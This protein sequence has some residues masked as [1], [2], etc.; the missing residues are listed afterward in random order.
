MQVTGA[1]PAP[2][3]EVVEELEELLASQTNEIAALEVHATARDTVERGAR[4]GMDHAL[5]RARADYEG[6]RMDGYLERLKEAMQG[7]QKLITQ[8]VN[9]QIVQM[10][11]AGYSEEAQDAFI[12]YLRRALAL[13]EGERCSDEA[14]GEVADVFHRLRPAL[15]GSRQSLRSL[16]RFAHEHGFRIRRSERGPSDEMSRQLD[17]SHYRDTLRSMLAA[18]EPL[19]RRAVRELLVPLVSVMDR[20]DLQWARWQVVGRV[21]FGDLR[22]DGRESRDRFERFFIERLPDAP[23]LHPRVLGH[24][25]RALRETIDAGHGAPEIAG[26][27]QRLLDDARQ[28]GRHP[29]ALFFGRRV[30]DRE[31]R[32][33]R[34]RNA[35]F[36][37]V[38]LVEK[39]TDAF[40][41]PRLEGRLDRYR[42]IREAAD[43]RSSGDIGA[44]EYGSMLAMIAVSD[45]RE[46]YQSRLLEYR[47]ELQRRLLEALDAVA[48]ALSENMRR[49]G[50]NDIVDSEGNVI[51][52]AL[53]QHL[54]RVEEGRRILGN[55]VSAR[56]RARVAT[57][58]ALSSELGDAVGLYLAARDPEAKSAASAEIAGLMTARAS[59]D[60]TI[61]SAG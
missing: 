55:L 30:L 41:S 53:E 27:T 22:F 8:E 13:A 44:I 59:I 33:V 42:A 5:K 18:G 48:E 29:D 56:E 7:R 60:A 9:E 6:R 37:L 40:F 15:P 52:S 57:Y 25:A 38:R 43:A 36:E 10:A 2:L 24:R 61:A 28:F 47:I 54:E 31:L 19:G 4:L 34:D 20:A 45:T 46:D 39:Q 17:R 1:G 32:K 3:G 50:S 12:R 23:T 21:E 14:A 11:A 16:S 26:A 49:I 35:S 58:I 51:V